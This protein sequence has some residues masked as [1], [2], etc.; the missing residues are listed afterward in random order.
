VSAVP[1]SADDHQVR[2]A[3]RKHDGESGRGD[4][5]D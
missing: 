5:A 3:R 1:V 2:G 4:L